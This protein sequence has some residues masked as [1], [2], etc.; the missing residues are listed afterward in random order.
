[1]RIDKPRGDRGRSPAETPEPP[2]HRLNLN[3]LY[4]LD[5][6][7]HAPTLTEAGR[8]VRLSQSAMSHALR[9]LRDHFGDDLV[10]H[11]AG[12]DQQLTSLGMALRSEVRRVLRDVDGTLNFALSFDPSTSTGTITVA[13]SDVVE[14]MLLGP[15]VQ[16]LLAAAPGL[17]INIVPLD[18]DV[19]QRALDRGADLLLL[20]A[21]LALPD[22]ETLPIL[23]EYISCLIW[24]GHSELADRFDIDEAQYRGARHVIAG[25]ERMLTMTVDRSTA[26]LLKA[27]RIAMRTSSQ[28]ALPGIIIGSDLLATGSSWLFQYFASIMPVRA[29]A[30]PFVQ[31]GVVTV[32]QWPAYRRRDPMLAWFVAQIEAY[33]ALFSANVRARDGH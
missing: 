15:V 12:G 6:I 13:A 28:A 22:L 25:D 1:M 9:R 30:A 14:Q 7:L 31:E 19:P 27:R 32:A 26:D 10:I 29:V 20:P 23:T 5:A 33:V 18:I 21:E 4:P 11:H 3:L 17:A 8:R 2:V 24:R 16:R